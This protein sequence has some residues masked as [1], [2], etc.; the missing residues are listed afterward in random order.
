MFIASSFYYTLCLQPNCII[1]GK[2]KQAWENIEQG[3]AK[4]IIA[5]IARIQARFRFPRY[6][7][8]IIHI[9][10]IMG[11]CSE[12]TPGGDTMKKR[13]FVWPGLILCLL[14]PLVASCGSGSPQQSGNSNPNP[15]GGELYVLDNYSSVG[16]QEVAQHIVA[17]PVGTANPAARLTLPAGLT[18]LKH[19]WVYIASSLSS[20]NGSAHTSISVLDTRSG[21][22]VRTFSL[23]GSYS[24]ADRG[25]ADS[26]LSGDGRW[27]ALREL[28]TPAGAT[29]I[30]LVD[31]QAGKLVKSFHLN[32][33]FTL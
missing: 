27:L 17:L 8:T 33:N 19:Q 28:N 4:V 10:T 12:H 29:N 32:G 22:T 6:N 15:A 20:G 11:L 5:L 21:A 24:T 23:P 25:D 26:M 9:T 18:D 3:F 16:Q 1:Y 30:A 2:D 14:I 31:T 13:L 7:E